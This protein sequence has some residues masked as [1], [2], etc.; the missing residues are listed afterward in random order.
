MFARH[1]K[2]LRAMAQ[3]AKRERVSGWRRK[4]KERMSP[5]ASREALIQHHNSRNF[6]RRPG[7]HFPAAKGL[8]PSAIINY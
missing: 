8:R 5:N 4:W 3:A 6:S 1:R 2:Q 7:F